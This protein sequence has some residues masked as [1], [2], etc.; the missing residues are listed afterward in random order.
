MVPVDDIRTFGTLS[1]SLK[2]GDELK[3]KRT[4]LRGHKSMEFEGKLDK[5]QRQRCIFLMGVDK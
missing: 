4:R 2:E 1:I 5:C 3:K